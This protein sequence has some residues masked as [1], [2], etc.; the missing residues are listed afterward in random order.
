MGP[1]LDIENLIK[2]SSLKYRTIV[3]GVYSEIFPVLLGYFDT[4]TTDENY[5]TNY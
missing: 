5:T 4:K 3:E 1:H 2:S